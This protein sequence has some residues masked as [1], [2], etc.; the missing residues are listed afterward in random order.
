[1][2]KLINIILLVASAIL[3]MISVTCE[4]NHAE[5]KETIKL[6][7]AY[8]IPWTGRF[9]P[10]MTMGPVILKALDYVK[11]RGL[12][13][14]YDIELHWRDTQCDKLVGVK[15]LIDIWRDNQDLDVIIGDACSAICYQASLLAGI[16]NVPII[17][18]GCSQQILSDKFAHPTFSRL[19]TPSSEKFRIVKELVM[20][21]GWQRVGIIS[22]AY[23]SYKDQSK[24]LFSELMLL[25]ITAFYYNINSVKKSR[26]GSDTQNSLKRI[27]KS[28]KEEVRVLIIY[29][30]GVM[31]KEMSLH[32]KEENMEKGYVFVVVS[33]NALN[34]KNAKYYL[35]WLTL[36]VF[37]P[38]LDEEE[39]VVDFNEPLFKGMPHSSSNQDGEGFSYAG[40]YQFSNSK[41]CAAAP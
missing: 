5:N 40:E 28:I 39:F 32:L 17:S 30:Y 14:N 19:V 31:L 7:M 24:K 29:T 12:L 27:M 6:K 15:M 3:T 35:N 10:G 25:N 23:V 22:D 36:T 4:S 34:T 13:S 18:W 33:D 37:V 8:L 38:Y 11:K 41:N 20:M 9:T 16:W 2:K 1:M 26:C 21:F